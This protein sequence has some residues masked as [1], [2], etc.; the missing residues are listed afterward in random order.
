MLTHVKLVVLSLFS[1]LDTLQC[2]VSSYN[3]QEALI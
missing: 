2:N 1:L 3:V